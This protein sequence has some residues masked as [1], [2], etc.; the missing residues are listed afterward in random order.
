MDAWHQTYAICSY[1]SSNIDT[2]CSHSPFLYSFWKYN[3]PWQE[4]L[5]YLFYTLCCEKWYV[6]CCIVNFYD[7]KKWNTWH[8]LESLLAVKKTKS[9]IRFNTVCY[10]M[11][12]T[13]HAVAIETFYI[14]RFVV[15]I[16]GWMKNIWCGKKKNRKTE[17]NGCFGIRRH[18]DD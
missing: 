13:P 10:K 16:F 15:K 14:P 6:S 4:I 3:Q 18:N 17:W 2:F 9:K 11:L 5:P 12:S 7:N 8:W 1:S